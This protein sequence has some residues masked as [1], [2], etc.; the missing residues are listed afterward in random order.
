MIS[1]TDVQYYENVK[2]RKTRLFLVFGA[3]APFGLFLFVLLAHVIALTIK[4]SH[5][6]LTL[7]QSIY[8]SISLPSNKIYSV[9]E[10]GLIALVWRTFF[11]LLLCIAVYPFGFFRRLKRDLRVAHTLV[12]PTKATQR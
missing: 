10:I 8:L 11:L 4:S 12:A 6:D 9:S 3:L 5:F 1:E 2:K 7:V